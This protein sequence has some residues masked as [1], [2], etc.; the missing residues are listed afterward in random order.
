M[1]LLLQ[2][3]LATLVLLAVFVWIMPNRTPRGVEVLRQTLGF[4]EF[5]R[6]A[7]AQSRGID[8]LSPHP[9]PSEVTS[10]PALAG[11]NVLVGLLSACGSAPPAKVVAPAPAESP[12]LAPMNKARQA[13]DQINAAQ[14]QRDKAI[15]NAHQ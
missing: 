6:R 14:E 9:W 7:W 8:F 15:E 13:V 11:I 12:L 5:L 4:Q 10:R 3:L 2:V 1:A